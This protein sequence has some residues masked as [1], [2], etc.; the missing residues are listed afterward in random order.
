MRLDSCL[1]GG[2]TLTDHTLAICCRW[3]DRTRASLGS[4]VETRIAQVLC[5]SGRERSQYRVPTPRTALSGPS[6][7]AN[8]KNS[9]SDPNV[10]SRPVRVHQPTGASTRCRPSQTPSGRCRSACKT[11]AIC[12][13]RV[14]DNR[15][16]ICKSPHVMTASELIYP[17]VRSE[18]SPHLRKPGHKTYL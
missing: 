14:E 16:V 1:R 12:I 6:S 15:D 10:R 18:I 4:P 3:S 8:G 2:R 9:D 11:C 13:L 7:V 17:H 5:A